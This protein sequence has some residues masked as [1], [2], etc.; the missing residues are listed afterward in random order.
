VGTIF[1]VDYPTR[2]A[3]SLWAFLPAE[4]GAPVCPF[5][6]SDDTVVVGRS[7]IHGAITVCRCK[8]CQNE[9]PEAIGEE[10]DQA[11]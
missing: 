9:W 2:T 6:D 10:P 3:A 5:C 7:G 1:I 4:Q 8:K 11:G